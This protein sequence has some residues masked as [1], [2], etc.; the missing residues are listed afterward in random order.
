[1]SDREVIPGWIVEKQDE[2]NFTFYCIDEEASVK[3]A[4]AWTNDEFQAASIAAQIHRHGEMM[5]RRGVQAGRTHMA[6]D[7]RRLLNA[8]PLELE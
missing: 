4:K 6:Q 2:E 7:L 5:W 3:V 1:M 8:A